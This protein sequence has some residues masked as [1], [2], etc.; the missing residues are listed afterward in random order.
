LPGFID[1]P[2]AVEEVMLEFQAKESGPAVPRLSLAVCQATGFFHA[3]KAG[4]STPDA[5]RLAAAVDRAAGAMADPDPASRILDIIPCVAKAYASLRF[6]HNGS[7]A[8]FA[9]G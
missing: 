7:Q 3:Q 4:L 6:E 8:S 1:D 2:R 9:S 5:A